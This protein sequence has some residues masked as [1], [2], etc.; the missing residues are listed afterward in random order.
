MK[1]KNIIH[2]DTITVTYSKIRNNFN[3][4]MYYRGTLV[5]L[6]DQVEANTKEGN[7]LRSKAY[8]LAVPGIYMR[9]CGNRDRANEV[10]L[11]VALWI[12]EA[13]VLDGEISE[14]SSQLMKLCKQSEIAS[15]DKR[16]AQNILIEVKHDLDRVRFHIST[17]E[18][19]RKEL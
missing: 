9:I 12:E 17:A 3:I 14:H 19:H 8:N 2:S 4:K 7:L 6:V 18:R 11:R 15:H 1:R 5:E 16:R 10:L 13:I